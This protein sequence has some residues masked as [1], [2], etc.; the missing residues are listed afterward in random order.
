MLGSL[1]LLVLFLFFFIRNNNKGISAIIIISLLNDMFA[2]S[3]GFSLP[4]HY[5]I[6]LAFLP[7]I[8][9]QYKLI[10]L[11]AKRLLAPIYLELFYLAFLAV[12]FGF[13]FPWE[14]KF[15]YQRT[16]SQKAEGRAII[17]IIK[18]ISEIGLV[19][20]L[21]LWLNTKQIT[22]NYLL[23]VTSIVIISSVIFTFIDL[24][25]GL[26]SILF[27]DLREVEGRFTALNVEPRS[28]GRICSFVL[29]LL[30]SFNNSS[31]SNIIKGGILFSSIGI[32]ISLSA[33]TYVM[34]LVWIVFYIFIIK[35]YKFF[36]IGIPILFVL[37]FF[38]NQNE[39]FREQTL[40][41]IEAT[42]AQDKDS[43]QKEKVNDNEPELFS[44]FEVFDRAA[45]N[46]LYNEPMYFITGTGPNLI[47]IPSS[48]YITASAYTIY[49]NRIDSVPHTFIIN[50]ISR[51]G[52]IGL[53]IWIVFFFKFKNNSKVLNKEQQAL[54]V[55]T[56][57]AYFI[58]ATSFFLFIIAILSYN[59]SKSS[60]KKIKLND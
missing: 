23:K 46:F 11:K 34:T 60:K 19:L 2:F 3:F 7:K 42:S 31:K 8:T 26:K 52:L 33:S 56:M 14:S 39:F 10:P 32:I 25:F 1:V 44:S 57:I 20:L 59:I 29:L 48:P 35:K 50:L 18:L 58:V 9:Y 6:S 30:I 53:L 37:L 41:K 24:F 12:F 54:F 5:L 28:F 45:L 16:W 21:L 36:L 40:K 38:L 27:S 43:E 47:S 13:I 15:D 22:V 49:E 17:Q 51:S 4:I 55:C